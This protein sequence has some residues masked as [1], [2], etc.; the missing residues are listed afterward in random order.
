M[1]DS[2]FYINDGWGDSLHSPTVEEMQK[3]LDKLGIDDPEHCA[4]WLSHTESGWNLECLPNNEVNLD[5]ETFD[6]HNIPPRHLTNVSRE[7]MLSLWQLLADGKIQELEK[8]SWLPGYTSEPLPPK[9]DPKEV[10]QDFWNELITA[11]R[12]PNAKCKIEEC[13][14]PPIVLTV[15]CPKHF[16]EKYAKISCPF[17]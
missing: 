2:G 11:D 8:E 10:H 13:F 9:L 12:I 17:D 15:F 4:V 3:Y 1:A 6:G 16:F 7:K 5:V 14:E